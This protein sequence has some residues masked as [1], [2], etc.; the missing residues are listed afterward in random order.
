MPVGIVYLPHFDRPYGH[1]PQK[2][3]I[4]EEPRFRGSQAPTCRQ[5][6]TS[7]IDRHQEMLPLRA[8]CRCQLGALET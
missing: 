3:K 1:I 5:R 8:G 2:L 4:T 6:G 7:K